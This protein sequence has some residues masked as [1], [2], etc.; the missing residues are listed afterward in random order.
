MVLDNLCGPYPL[1]CSS[2]CVLYQESLLQ[3]SKLVQGRHYPP[4]AEPMPAPQ[5]QT[6]CVILSCLVMADTILIHV[7]ILIV[8]VWC[9]WAAV[10]SSGQVGP[11]YK[12]E[13]QD[14]MP[15]MVLNRQR[16][17]SDAPRRVLGISKIFPTYRTK[18]EIHLPLSSCSVLFMPLFP[19]Q[20]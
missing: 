16:H 18:I 20:L 4:C 1:P 5:G 7:S 8:D 3:V 13:K 9:H 12:L 2:H 14:D 11:H 10:Q 15:F 17:L 19:N 6:S